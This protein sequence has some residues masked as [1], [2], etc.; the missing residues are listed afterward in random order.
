M[1]Q[2][3][4]LNLIP[5]GVYPV[6]TASQYDEKRVITFT[7][8]DGTSA[9]TIPNG[10]EI[11]VR[12]LKGDDK[13]FIY[14]E[15]DLLPDNTPIV[16]WSGNVIT[17][18][19]ALQMTA[20]YGD[21]LTQF[22]LTNGGMTIATLNF[23]LRVQR[24]PAADGDISETELPAIIAEATEQ[25]RRA[26]AA[27]VVADGRAE[28]SEAWA[29]GTRDGSPVGSSDPTYHNN[30]KYYAD[31]A[32]DAKT[33]AETAQGLAEMAQGKAEDAQTAA[34][35]A[36]G[37]AE[38]AQTAAESAQ[39]AAETSELNAEAWAVGTKDGTAVPST[40]PQHH[41]NS[42]YWS[43]LAAQY[44][45][46]FGSAVKWRGAVAFANIPTSG[47]MNGDLY[48][49]TDSFTTDSRFV[50]GSGVSEP[51]G[52]DI[53]WN[54]NASK[55][56]INTPSGVTSFN[57]RM[58]AVT[59]QS[60]DYSKGDVGLGN[61]DN[62]SDLNKPIS[63]AT[64]TALDGKMKKATGT[65][66]QFVGYDSNGNPEA[67]SLPVMTGATTLA[68]GAAGLVPAPTVSDREKF[69]GGDGA[70]H[71]PAGSGSGHTIMDENGNTFTNRPVLQ[72]LDSDI[73]DDSVNDRTIITPHGGTTIVQIPSVVGTTFTYTGSAIG[74]QVTGLDTEHTTI[75]GATATDVG[76]Y[77]LTAALNDP[78]RMVWADMTTEDKTFTYTIT[79]MPITIPTV[80]GSF[81]YD[82]TEK[83]CTISPA[84]SDYYTQTGTTAST[85][86]GTFSITFELNDTA[87]TEWSD[88][89]TA[90]KVKNWSIAKATP[91]LTVSPASVA[92][93]GNNNTATSTV[94][95][96]GNGTLSVS[97]SST[98]IAT[99]SISG[100]TVTITC[101]SGGTATITVSASAT[102]NYNAKTATISVQTE[103]VKIVTFHDGTDA[104]I[105]AMLDA[106]Y[107]GTI[108]WAEMG[109][110][111]GDTRLI[112]L[113]EMNAPSP[114][115]AG[116]KWA[117]QDITIVIVAHDHNDL[118]TPINGHTKACITVQ[119]R[120]CMNNN[121]TAW[122]NS[123]CIHVNGDSSFDATFTKWANL[124][125]RTYLNGIVLSAIP[126]GDF[127]SAI[128]QSNH[129][130]HTTYN[131]TGSEPVVTDTLFL[132]SYPEIFGT[133]S[134][135]TYAVTSP[136]EGTQW[137]YYE[138]SA[139][140]IKYGNNNGSSN[141]TAQ[142]WWTGSPSKEYNTTYLYQWCCVQTNGL[143]NRSGGDGACALAP[144]WCM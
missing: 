99:A 75:T 56:D 93:Q 61:V 115:A 86:A 65:A 109:W 72:F 20:C 96:S 51:A 140:R 38:D 28:D 19:T 133:A 120:E 13:V 30:S 68:N 87:N 82:G 36:Q 7:L 48:D 22:K 144:A 71:T 26:E 89:T 83:S 44:A 91:T 23:V 101:V 95:Y 35:T 138:T 142:F 54:E 116:S 37:K 12:G 119:T 88:G 143:L 52:T 127:K 117:A 70:W 62:T 9:Y 6:V 132:P 118:A 129:Y 27:A 135:N 108:T 104:Q 50:I 128:K 4:N 80:T 107:N 17:L 134:N 47:M 123:G 92:I 136:V 55:W 32:G 43:D 24:D 85:N 16:S 79:K 74:P 42:K 31:E 137:K 66:G 122:Q 113:N 77:T 53:I 60:G 112:H 46:Q 58:G 131:G 67:Q 57:G 21:V 110:A 141:G 33:A 97:S 10:T 106:Y 15:D 8:Y 76:S 2:N 125:M 49:I 98:S 63:T 5:D 25:M 41:N 34:E 64:Q 105:K 1:N 29:V 81:T 59:P 124:Y 139:N 126:I 121:A 69:L 45:A 102:T 73:T 11:E 100:R 94:T 114:Q 3:I 111:V 39:T 90:D 78:S 14:N 130:R 40:D 103:N 84:S 18:N